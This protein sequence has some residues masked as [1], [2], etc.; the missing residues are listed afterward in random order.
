M[1]NFAY[2]KFPE[3]S[4]TE[5]LRMFGYVDLSASEEARL[6]QAKYDEAFSSR[7]GAGKF[8]PFRYLN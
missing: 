2:V 8:T 1:G 4:P 6:D 5:G 7:R 3:A